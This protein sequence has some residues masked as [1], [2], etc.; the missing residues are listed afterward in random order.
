MV[1]DKNLNNMP[2]N[3]LY[4]M[5]SMYMKTAISYFE[6]DCYKN[7]SEYKDFEQHELY[8]KYDGTDNQLYVGN[9]DEL[10]DT[11]YEN[12]YIGYRFSD[13]EVYK[14]VTEFTYD[15]FESIITIEQ[16]LGLDGGTCELYVAFY[17]IGVI[18]ECAGMKEEAVK[19]YKKCG[20]YVPAL[21]GIER[22][23]E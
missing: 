18:Y 21:T 15:E 5:L 7:I 12:I 8:F 20:E 13:D 14:E 4:K 17:N 22:I 19:Y 23:T 1:N 11:T 9:I 2:S 16:D 6:N 10:M 3:L